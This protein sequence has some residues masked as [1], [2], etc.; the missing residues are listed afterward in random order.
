VELRTKVRLLKRLR[1]RDEEDLLRLI[2]NYNELI[3]HIE[4]L[5]F[6]AFLQPIQFFESWR[7]S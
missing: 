1:K 6:Q 3:I 4:D 7:I 5:V 2:N